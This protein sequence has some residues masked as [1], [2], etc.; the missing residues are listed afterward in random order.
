MDMFEMSSGQR[1]IAS[2]M[3]I[4]GVADLPEEFVRRAFLMICR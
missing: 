1:L 3:R 2:Y 4:G